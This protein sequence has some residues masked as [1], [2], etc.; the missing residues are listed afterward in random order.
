MT[1]CLLRRYEHESVWLKASLA[2][3]LQ[4]YAQRS[5]YVVVQFPLRVGSKGEP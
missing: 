2:H 1:K 3:P 5:S 4:Y